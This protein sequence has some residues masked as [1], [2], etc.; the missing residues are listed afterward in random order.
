MA[1]RLYGDGLCLLESV[2]LRVTAMDFA[3][4]QIVVHEGKGHKERR[5]LRPAAGQ[6]PL[7]APVAHVRHLHQHDWAQG[8]G[9]G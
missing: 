8:F 3:S 4:H 5:T 2:R 1:S 6:E 9:R 7:A